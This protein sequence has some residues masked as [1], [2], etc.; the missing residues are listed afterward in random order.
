MLK[1]NIQILHFIRQFVLPLNIIHGYEIKEN[2]VIIF[3]KNN[4]ILRFGIK[5]FNSKRLKIGISSRYLVFLQKSSAEVVRDFY[6]IKTSQG[7]LSLE[8]CV[9]RNVSGELFLVIFFKDSRLCS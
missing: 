5:L 2:T 6:F 1:K 4:H 3:L 8:E 9:A 7:I